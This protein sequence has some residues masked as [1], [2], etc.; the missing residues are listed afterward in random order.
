MRFNAVKCQNNFA[1]QWS[2]IKRNSFKMLQLR[3]F[4]PLCVYNHQHWCTLKKTLAFIGQTIFALLIQWHSLYSLSSSFIRN[5]CFTKKKSKFQ[6]SLKNLM[7]KTSSIRSILYRSNPSDAFAGR[8]STSIASTFR[9]FDI[10]QW[11]MNQLIEF[12]QMYRT[13]SSIVSNIFIN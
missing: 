3:F 7:A 11:Y 12:N 2:L 10:P 6:Q 1:I 8:F 9:L 13:C 4:F 5:K